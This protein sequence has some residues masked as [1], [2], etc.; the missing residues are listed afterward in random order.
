VSGLPVLLLIL[1]VLCSFEAAAAHG[2]DRPTVRVTTGVVQINGWQGDLVKHNPNLSRWHWNPV[3]V[4][5]QGLVGGGRKNTSPAG[6]SIRSSAPPPMLPEGSR[7]V[8]PVHVPFNPKALAEVEAKAQAKGLLM[9]N[10]S[11]ETV[12]GKLQPGVKE[13]E[14]ALAPPAQSTLKQAEYST[15]DTTQ[16]H[17]NASVHGELKEKKVE[18]AKVLPASSHLTAG[19]KEKKIEELKALP[20][21]LSKAH[22]L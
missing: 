15:Y 11:N 2:A 8:K 6:Q 4:Y 12:Q 3:Y 17:S 1:L 13:R 20:K 9:Q 18:A 19:S 21:S 16:I 7:Y 22:K 10:R 5:K 14:T